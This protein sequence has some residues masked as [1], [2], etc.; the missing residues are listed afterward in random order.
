MTPQQ[1]EARRACWL[2]AAVGLSVTLAALVDPS[3][4][5]GLGPL[6]V[7]LAMNLPIPPLA[8]AAEAGATGSFCWL[9]FGA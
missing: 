6:A 2:G 7:R 9:A 5:G 3:L 8:G 1:D 4:G